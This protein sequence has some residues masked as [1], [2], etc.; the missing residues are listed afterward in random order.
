LEANLAKAPEWVGPLV[1]AGYGLQC[2]RSGS[3][4]TPAC[5]IH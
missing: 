3:S 2:T 1:E 5:K 4:L